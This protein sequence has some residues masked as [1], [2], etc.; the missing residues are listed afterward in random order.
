[1]ATIRNCIC[2]ILLLL[3]CYH[4]GVSQTRLTEI[5][6]SQVGV[7]EIP[8]GSNWGPAVKQYLHSVKINFPAA[9]CAAF[10]HWCLDSAGIPNAVTAWSP[11]AQNSKN[12]IWYHNKFYEDP[13]PG[14]VFCLWFPKLRRIAHTGFYDHRINASIYQTVEGNTN[15]AGSRE[16]DGVYRKYRSFRA[17]YSISRWH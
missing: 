7:R 9:W 16:G 4:T 5:Y 15:E 1:M 17:T 10:V 3:F 11:T 6:S 14:D 12:L 8:A 13:Q 2:S